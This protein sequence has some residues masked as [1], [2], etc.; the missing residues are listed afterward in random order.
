MGGEVGVESALGNGSTFWFTALLQKVERR[1][2]LASTSA[3]DAEALI[4][5]HYKGF[6]I[7][8]VDDE[9]ANLEVARFLLEELGLLVD[10]AEDGVEAIDLARETAYAVILMDMQMPKL[11][12]LEATRQI[13]ALS[14]YRNIPILAMT[15]NA[16]SEDRARCLEAGMNDSLI[17]PFDP[18]MLFSTLLKQL[19]QRYKGRD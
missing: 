18:D 3:I 19:E 8:L 7:L 16:F 13:R 1:D 6:R 5:H 15:A 10:T 12:G 9:P 17:K 4:R 14:G 2:K 11:D